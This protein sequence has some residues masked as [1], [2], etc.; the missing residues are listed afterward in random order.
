MKSTGEVMGI[1]SNFAMAFAKAE[2]AAST[3]LPN[4]GN[5]FVSV[6]DEDKS[7]LDQI[8]HG[9]HEMGFKLIATGGT[10]RHIRKLG[11]PCAEINKVAEGSPHIVDAM[12]RTR[13][14][15]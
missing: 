13:S 6:R 14:R 2:L 10:A 9:L 4:T 1:D 8:A 12:R 15:W 3:V 11:I 7:E 5:V